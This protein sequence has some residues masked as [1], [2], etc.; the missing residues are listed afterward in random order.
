MSRA[1]LV[2]IVRGAAGRGAAARAR[3]SPTATATGP[4]ARRQAASDR[5]TALRPALLSRTEVAAARVGRFVYVV[6]G[7]EQRSGG[8]T[9]AVERY[10]I[11]RD[12][13]RRVRSMPVGAQPPGGRGVP[14]ARL[15]ARRLHRPRRPAR[16]GRLALPLRPAARPLV[17]P[18]ERAHEARRAGGGRDRRQAVRGRR[19]ERAAARSRRSRSTTSRAGA[20][21]AGPTWRRRA[22]TSRA[23]S[24]AA[25]ST[26]SRGASPGRAT[27]RSP[28]ATCRARAAGSSCPTCASRAAGSAR[29]RSARRVVVAGG[30]EA[31]GTIGEVE[32]YD[33]AT[34]PLEPAARHAHAAP[35]ARR[36]VA[37]PPRV[38]DRGRPD[39]GLRLLERSRR[40]TR[41]GRRATLG[42]A[43]PSSVMSAFDVLDRVSRRPPMS[44]F[45]FSR[46]AATARSSERPTVSAAASRGPSLT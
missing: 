20:G 22:S 5:W 19:R 43:K 39:A 12:R 7:F 18:A 11:G 30:E 8:T 29:P 27:S 4:T 32:A 14:R 42:R 34:R 16:R 45:S 25:P 9:A 1:A 6:G 26:C 35:R 3:A 46:R 21:R 41:T 2:A 31:T 36:R 17:A 23:P 24:R 13:W 44:V 15:R 33:P 28:S 10:D 38:R 37:R 40:S